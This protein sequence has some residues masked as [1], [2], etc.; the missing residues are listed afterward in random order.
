MKDF[1]EFNASP[2]V[3]KSSEE[4]VEVFDDCLSEADADFHAIFRC[5]LK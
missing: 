2:K 4:V 1:F 3:L 5:H